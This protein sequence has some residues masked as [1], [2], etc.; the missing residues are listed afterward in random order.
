MEFEPNWTT[1]TTNKF[2]IL[3]ETG[4]DGHTQTAGLHNKEAMM[5]E[6]G[7]GKWVHLHTFSFHPY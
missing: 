7:S 4:L 5:D 6:V 3:L 1:H 2:K